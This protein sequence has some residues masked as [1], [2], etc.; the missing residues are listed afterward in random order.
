MLHEMRVQTS[1]QRG[2]CRVVAQLAQSIGQRVI[3]RVPNQGVRACPATPPHPSPPSRRSCCSIPF[4]VSTSARCG[5]TTQARIVLANEFFAGWAGTDVAALAGRPLAELVEDLTP[6]H[7]QAIRRGRQ[8]RRAAAPG[9]GRAPAAAGACS[10]CARAASTHDG[11]ALIGAAA[12]PDRRPRRGRG[13]RRPA[14]RGARVD[15]ARP[16]AALGAG[17]AV[18]ARRGAGARGRVLGAAGREE[19]HRHARRRPQPAAGLRRRAA[20][21]ADR[22][23]RGLV[24]H[25]GVA[26]RA[27][28]GHRHRHR[29]AVGR[30]PQPAAP[31]AM[32]ACWST[33]IIAGN[34][35]VVATFALYYRT[36]RRGAAV[37]PPHGRGLRAA[38]PR[39]AAARG[40]PHRDRAPRLLRPAH[41]PAQPAPVQ[42]PRAPDA[43]DGGSHPGARRAAAVRHRPLQDHQRLAGPQRRR[44]GAARDGAAA[45]GR[46]RRQRHRRAPGRRRVRGHAAALQPGRGDARGRA[47]AAR[48]GR[49]AAHRGHADRGV[50]QH[51][52]RA[53]P[54]G[55]RRAGAAGEER[56][57]G[58]VRG[59]ARAA[60]ARRASSP[61]R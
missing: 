10:R 29:P 42:R 45:A 3:D 16:A 14:A 59:Q 40:Q 1:P 2:R 11:R 52:H 26:A 5:W 27:G 54:A 6:E 8:R 13:H 33:P 43:A 49:A 34:G 28:G 20:R 17:P 38:V 21:R 7:W 47:P 58:D 55:R 48:A 39:R 15:R 23:A 37:P 36:A 44:R 61:P 35:E 60:A 22:P 51:R 25:R 46:D 31:A 18:P 53:V 24:R 30:L 50:H 19:R 4:G 12:D 57:D 56:R 9:D 41:R 32:A